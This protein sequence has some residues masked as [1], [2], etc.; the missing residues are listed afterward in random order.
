MEG[1]LPSLH[2]ISHTHH[3]FHFPPTLSPGFN[4]FRVCQIILLSAGTREKGPQTFAALMPHCTSEWNELWCFDLDPGLFMADHG[5]MWGS[6]HCP[7]A[8][9]C[10]DLIKCH[11]NSKKTLAFPT[12]G[13]QTFCFKLLSVEGSEEIT[14][15]TLKTPFKIVSFN[16]LFLLFFHALLNLQPQ[17]RPIQQLGS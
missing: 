13:T 6:K 2:K 8:G 10:W 4:A 11:M 12:Q 9:L 15:Y 7:R 1:L 14:S 16:P 17:L 5:G 3:I